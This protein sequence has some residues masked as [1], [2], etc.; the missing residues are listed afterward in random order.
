MYKL[1]LEPMILKLNEKYQ[2]RLIFRPVYGYEDDYIISNMGDIISI[3]TTFPY[4]MKTSI[5]KSGYHMVTIRRGKE[6]KAEYVSNLMLNTF[7]GVRMNRLMH[8]SYI[9]GNIHNLN[10]NNLVWKNRSDIIKH[11]YSIA[12]LK[13]RIPVVLS[14]ATKTLCFDTTTQAAKHLKT[15]ASHLKIL[16]DNHEKYKGYT[17][18]F[19]K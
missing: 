17:I 2:T 1:D 13:T 19:G 15:T 11:L 8:C 16:R 7:K 14:K 9:D 5:L 4:L 6:V 10:I 3:R 18:S 12:L